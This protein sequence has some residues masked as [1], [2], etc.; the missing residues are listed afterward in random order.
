MLGEKGYERVNG[1]SEQSGLLDPWEVT[2][3]LD[4][5]CTSIGEN[6]GDRDDG[7][8]SGDGVLCGEIPQRRWL[9]T[10]GF[11]RMV[12][13]RVRCMTRTVGRSLKAHSMPTQ[14]L[15]ERPVV[16]VHGTQ[17]RVCV[18]GPLVL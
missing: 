1:F 14:L 15:V 2:G 10:E 11:R 3:L 16:V 7:R 17:G 12:E 8:K 13:L 6:V 18:D 5:G 9:R 4:H